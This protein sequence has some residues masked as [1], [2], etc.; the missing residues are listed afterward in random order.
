MTDLFKVWDRKWKRWIE[1]VDVTVYGDGTFTADRRGED[2]GDVIETAESRN[3]DLV[4]VRASGLPDK[5]GR[6]IFESDIVRRESDDDDGSEFTAAVV[7]TGGTF[8]LEAPGLDLM[9]HYELS[10]YNDECVIVGN[11]HVNPEVLK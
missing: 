1:G 6:H 2:G 4:L 11:I 9:G 10:W 7:Y 5:D 8:E 3:D